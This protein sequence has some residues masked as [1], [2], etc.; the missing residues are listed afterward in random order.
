MRHS[1]I[2]ADHGRHAARPRF[3]GG[4]E[5]LFER[6]FAGAENGELPAN[7]LNEIKI[8]ENEVDALLPG[9]PAHHAEERCIL[10]RG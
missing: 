9:E 1:F 3:R 5:S 6:C 7:L 4:T 10:I 2:I 8:S